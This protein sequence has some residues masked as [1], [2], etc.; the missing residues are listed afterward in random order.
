MNTLFTG[1]HT[2][3][4]D[5][6]SSTNTYAME[7]LK[8]GSLTEGTLIST[9]AQTGGRGQLGNAWEAEPGKNLT[10]SLVMQPR[11]VPA[12]RQFYL[13][14]ITSLAVLGM[15]TEFLPASQYDI[16]IKWPNDVLVNGQKIAGILIENVLAGVNIQ[17]SVIGVGININQG[18]FGVMKRKATSLQLLLGR[19]V[20]VNE[21]L[22]RFCKHF[23][24]LYLALKQGRHDTINR[25]YLHNLYRYNQTALYAVEGN[26][27]EAKMVAV[28][29]HGLL[30]LETKKGNLLKFNFKEIAFL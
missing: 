21:P 16:Q 26:T 18:A 6:V 1:K 7:L 8:K 9:F 14:K 12:T 5:E 15:L 22:E 28:E 20:N 27:F 10:F 11:F 29:E 17:H 4:L 23:E 24:A 19:E 3:T 13:S 25:Q 30:V 2:I